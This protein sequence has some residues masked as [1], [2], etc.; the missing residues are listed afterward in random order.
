M[1]CLLDISASI[2]PVAVRDEFQAMDELASRLHRGDQLVNYPDC[3]RRKK[4]YPRPHRSASGARRKSGLR[5]RSG[6]V[7]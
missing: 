1:F 3:K 4:Q 5:H 7:S 2:Y 6:A